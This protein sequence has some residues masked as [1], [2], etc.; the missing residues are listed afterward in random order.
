MYASNVFFAHCTMTSLACSIDKLLEGGLFTAE[1]TAVVGP[2]AS[3]KT[4]VG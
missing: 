4:Q 3:G 2:V 1:V